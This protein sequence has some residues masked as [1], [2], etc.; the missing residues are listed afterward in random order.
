M[1]IT[2]A[3]GA[4]NQFAV[5]S[6]KDNIFAVFCNFSILSK[7]NIAQSIFNNVLHIHNTRRV[8]SRVFRLNSS[9]V[10]YER[11]QS[12]ERPTE[13]N[14]HLIK[15]NSGLGGADDPKD[16]YYSVRMAE[17]DRQFLKFEWEGNYF[18]FTCLPNGLASATRPFTKLLK[19]V[20]AGLRSLGHFC[21][22]H[23]DD[24][25]LMRYIYA[26]C[27]ENIVQ[28]VNMFLKLG[29]VIHPTKSVLIPTQELKFLGFLLNNISMSIRLPP[30]K[31]TY[32]RQA[33]EDLLHQ[34]NLTIREV[35]HVIGLIVSSFQ[36]EQY[37][38]LF[39]RYLEQ[40]KIQAL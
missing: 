7:Q 28:T 19:L 30:R 13:P 9:S 6:A 35:A 25:F 3:F 10:K 20:Y 18:Q 32:V 15:T 2:S 24:S 27:E 26:S 33:Y 40:D 38:E 17:D 16:A 4:R 36:G 22:G 23:I 5:F 29:F 12:D 1:R 37:G 21:M 31:V 14:Q 11:Q 8:T 34:H 39:Y